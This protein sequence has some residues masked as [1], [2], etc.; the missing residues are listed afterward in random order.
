MTARVEVS[1]EIKIG[2]VAETALGLNPGELSTKVRDFVKYMHPADQER[3]NVLLWT[4]QNKSGGEI[5]TDFRMRHADNSYRWFDLEAASVPTSDR[6]SLRCVG[7][8]RD[9]TDQKRSQARLMHE[10]EPLSVSDADD[11][12]AASDVVVVSHAYGR[13]PAAA[14]ART[15]ARTGRR[16]RRSSRSSSSS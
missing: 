14:T 4:L 2:A 7:L 13:S 9:V 16:S 6:R 10:L 15:S 1:D 8:L 3:F 11:L 5:R 12:V